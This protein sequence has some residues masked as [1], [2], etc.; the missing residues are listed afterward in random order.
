VLQEL[1]GLRPAGSVEEGHLTL[2]AM[3]ETPE[4]VQACLQATETVTGNLD[5]PHTGVFAAWS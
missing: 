4:M 1:P 3:V 2:M 5:G